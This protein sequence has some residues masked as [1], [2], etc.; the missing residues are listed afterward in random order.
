MSKQTAELIHADPREIVIIEGYNLRQDYGD[1]KEFKALIKAEGVK[2]PGTARR[3]SEGTLELTSQGHRRIKASM[4][5]LDDG[6]SKADNGADLRQFPLLVDSEDKSDEENI[7]EMLSLNSGKQLEMIEYAEGVMRILSPLLEDKAALVEKRKELGKALGKSHTYMFSLQSLWEQTNTVKRKITTGRIT[8]TTVLDIVND[9]KAGRK[10]W[11]QA[12]LAVKVE[13]KVLKAIVAA[14]ERGKGKATGADAGTGR[15]GKPAGDGK[16]EA[17][18]A[19]DEAAKARREEEKQ[20]L[21]G[22]RQQNGRIEKLESWS[23]ELQG[24]NPAGQQALAIVQAVVGFAKGSNITLID[25]KGE[26]SALEK[27]VDQAIKD[28]V[29][30]AKDGAK[31]AK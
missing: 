5:L 24:K 4:E 19:L 15:A 8:A 1:M 20:E 12:E 16:S 11:D 29:K 10:E 22:L 17:Q 30:A 3:N 6:V 26:L 18:L 13:E 27:L 2:V 7:I 25:V 21:R 23:G 9:V 31:A 14:E 28:A